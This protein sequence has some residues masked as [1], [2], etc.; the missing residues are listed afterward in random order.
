M[1]RGPAAEMEAVTKAQ[2]IDAIFK[3]R[4][5]HARRVRRH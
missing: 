4:G 1:I 3:P 5:N 2:L